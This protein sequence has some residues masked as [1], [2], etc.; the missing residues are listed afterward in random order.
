MQWC[1][2][3]ACLAYNCWFKPL[4]DHFLPRSD[5]NKNN[6]LIK[7]FLQGMLDK[8]ITCF[9]VAGKDFSRSRRSKTS[10]PDLNSFQTILIGGWGRL[11]DYG[12]GGRGGGLEIPRP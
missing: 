10:F 4:L 2:G 9:F 12:G 1:S 5:Q 8:K 7:V 11:R 6:W 3:I